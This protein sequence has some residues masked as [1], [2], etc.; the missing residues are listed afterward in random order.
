[1]HALTAS[2]PHVAELKSAGYP[3]VADLTKVYPVGSPIRFL[4][5]RRALVEQHPDAVEAFL[6][7]ITRA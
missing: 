2:G 1:V 7:A 4:V 5:A 3:V 6:R